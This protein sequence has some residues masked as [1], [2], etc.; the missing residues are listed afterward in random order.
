MRTTR[1]QAVYAMSQ[2]VKCTLHR[3]RSE[4]CVSPLYAQRIKVEVDRVD[5]SSP[6]VICMSNTQNGRAHPSY[7]P[8]LRN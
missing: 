6:T 5:M 3:R 8:S 7:R 4:I 1:W 2:S